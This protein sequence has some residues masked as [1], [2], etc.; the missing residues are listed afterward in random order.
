M[1]LNLNRSNCT[2]KAINQDQVSNNF[3]S[4][5]STTTSHSCSS[6]SSRLSTAPRLWHR[7]AIHSNFGLQMGCMEQ[8]TTSLSVAIWRHTP[9]PSLKTCRC[10]TI[11]HNQGRACTAQMTPRMLKWARCSSRK[12]GLCTPSL[13]RSFRLQITRHHWTWAI[14]LTRT[15]PPMGRGTHS[16]CSNSTAAILS[17]RVRWASS[18]K[19]LDNR[20]TSKPHMTCSRLSS[21]SKQLEVTLITATSRWSC[22]SSPHITSMSRPGPSLL[23]VSA[24]TPSST[25][26]TTTSIIN[27]SNSSLCTHKLETSIWTS[28]SDL[29]TW[30][31]IVWCQMTSVCPTICCT[32]T[33]TRVAPYQLAA[34]RCKCSNR[35]WKTLRSKMQTR[36]RRCPTDRCR[37]MQRTHLWVRVV[38]TGRMA[39]CMAHH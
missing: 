5:S 6:T 18:F 2:A 38:K 15:L 9:I 13:T 24:G 37:T 4:S 27:N 14:I 17:T 30:Q 39:I 19:R 29:T 26:K 8:T 7:R 32:R 16:R 20:D 23:S 34:G 1:F 35:L 28:I 11:C 3:N 12:E 36:T 10:K 31:R 25:C 22:R 21:T 33:T